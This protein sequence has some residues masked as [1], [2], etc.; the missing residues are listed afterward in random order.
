M[1]IVLANL[2]APHFSPTIS[3]QAPQ[4][5]SVHATVASQ[6]LDSITVSF[7]T[8][9]NMPV[10][11]V[12]TKLDNILSFDAPELQSVT[13]FGVWFGTSTLV[14]VFE[15]CV[16]F[17]VGN[18]DGGKDRPLYLMFEAERGILNRVM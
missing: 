10:V 12:P 8:K 2:T 15:D 9:T 5:T 1:S 3:P 7:S 17:G 13:K 6:C 14:V 18:S 11:E 4:V 16:E